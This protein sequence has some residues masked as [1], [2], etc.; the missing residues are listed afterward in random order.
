MKKKYQVIECIYQLHEIKRKGTSEKV[1]SC[2]KCLYYGT[3][4]CRKE[5]KNEETV[6]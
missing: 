5:R 1:L 4:Q 3:K 2:E 6:L